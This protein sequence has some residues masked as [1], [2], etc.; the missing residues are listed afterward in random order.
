MSSPPPTDGSSFRPIWYVAPAKSVA[1][2]TCKADLLAAVLSGLIDSCSQVRE[3]GTN[4]WT[5]AAD[6]RRI[7]P[8]FAYP[9]KIERARRLFFLISLV[10]GAALVVPIVADGIKGFRTIMGFA[11]V[12][13]VLRESYKAAV[14]TFEL[15]LGRLVL[16]FAGGVVLA[17]GGL[18]VSDALIELARLA[19][20]PQLEAGS[21]WLTLAL[22]IGIVIIIAAMSEW[23]WERWKPY[24]KQNCERAGR[25]DI[26]AKARSAQKQAKQARIHG[27]L[28]F[29]ECGRQVGANGDCY[30]GK[31]K[32]SKR[33]GHGVLI[34]ATGARYEGEW[35]KGGRHG[36]GV[37]IL[38]DGTETAGRWQEDRRVG[39]AD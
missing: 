5:S 28:G 2:I 34:W 10:V 1:K 37:E 26:P 25:D 29:D 31:L 22:F 35:K 4:L 23:Y 8:M 7:A 36:Y 13:M 18:I 15:S 21:D 27:L 9:E 3:D 24:R 39:D 38:P 20:L 11:F 17:I 32:E 33:D 30:E 14:E 6:N 16:L 19:L 12:F